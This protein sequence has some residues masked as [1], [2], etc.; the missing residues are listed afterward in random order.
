ML[1]FLVTHQYY[2]NLIDTSRM[3]GACSAI[4]IAHNS[5]ALPFTDTFLSNY[6]HGSHQPHP[7]FYYTRHR[8]PH[9]PLAQLPQDLADAFMPLTRRIVPHP[10]TTAFWR[11]W[12]NTSAGMGCA[13]SQMIQVVAP[14]M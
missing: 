4:N 13:A 9:L 14:S 2:H 1:G 8:P 7:Q 12:S 3:L 5:P 10:W 6:S 11:G